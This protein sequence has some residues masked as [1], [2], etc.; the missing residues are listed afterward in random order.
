[1][2]VVI[3]GDATTA[4]SS[5]NFFA[6]IG[7]MQPMILAPNIPQTNAE[8]IYIE[9]AKDCTLNNVTVT[10]Q[11]GKDITLVNCENIELK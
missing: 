11:N 8:G 6:I 9:K 1:M 7:S 3:N 2:F 4:G 10:N 5:F